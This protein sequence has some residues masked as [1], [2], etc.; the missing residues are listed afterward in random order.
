MLEPGTSAPNFVLPGVSAGADSAIEQYDLSD[1]LADGPVIVN[2]Y[3]F[4]FHPEC[5][6]QLCDLS[7]LS[8]FDINEDVTVFAISTDRSFSHRA[9]ADAENLD[10]PLLSDSDGSVAEAFDV[11]YDEFQNHRRIAKRSV[12]V[13]DTDGI[14]QYAWSA[15]EPTTQPDW[16]SVAEA[17]TSVGHV[18]SIP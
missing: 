9:F 5:T 14:I 10:F 13:I 18:Q 6:E 4:D 1:A 17:L 2:F 16:S 7:N 8:W 3:L 15:D 11:L 12:F